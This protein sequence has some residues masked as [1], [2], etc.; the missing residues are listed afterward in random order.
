MIFV[1]STILF[2]I[3][4]I[5][6]AIEKSQLIWHVCLLWPMRFAGVAFFHRSH[7]SVRLPVLRPRCLGALAPFR[8]GKF[9]RVIFQASLLPFCITRRFLFSFAR[10]PRFAARSRFS[11]LGN[12]SQYT[13]RWNWQALSRRSRISWPR[14][15]KGQTN[16]S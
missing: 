9:I 1:F 13:R 7:R 3:S 14:I 6:S 11:L 2:C 16:A 5:S 15:S 8:T 12:R 10:F 4:N